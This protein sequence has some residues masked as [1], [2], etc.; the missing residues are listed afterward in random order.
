MSGSRAL[1]MSWDEW[2]N[3]DATAL[4]ALVKAGKIAPEGSR[5]TVRREGS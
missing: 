2:A 3:H 1:L 5:M 4:A